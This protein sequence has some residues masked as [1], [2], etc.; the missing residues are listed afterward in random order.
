MNKRRSSFCG[1][2][3]GSCGA[4]EE[5]I[6]P[7]STGK[8]LK[9][10]QILNKLEDEK[11][12]TR[13][14]TMKEKS[15][16]GA[17]ERISCS[18]SRTSSFGR[19]L[20]LWT[21]E[22][23]KCGPN[24]GSS[25]GSK[26][27]E[28][29][30]STAERVKASTNP[31]SVE[32]AV[33]RKLDFQLNKAMASKLVFGKQNSRNRPSADSNNERI[34]APET[35]SIQ[36][37]SLLDQHE[38]NRNSMVSKG[39]NPNCPGQVVPEL[40][41]DGDLSGADRCRRKSPQHLK[42]KKA[43]TSEGPGRKVSRSLFLSAGS[44]SDGKM[45]AVNVRR[46]ALEKT[47]KPVNSVD[48]MASAVDCS[49]LKSEDDQQEDCQETGESRVFIKKQKAAS[50]LP[51]LP[52]KEGLNKRVSEF[53][54]FRKRWDDRLF[55]FGLGFGV[56]FMITSSKKEI[57]KLRE[58]QEQT[59][60]LVKDLKQEV[61]RGNFSNGSSQMLQS[62][63][64]LPSKYRYANREIEDTKNR[65]VFRSQNSSGRLESGIS[66]NECNSS[67]HSIITTESTPQQSGMAQLEAELEAELERM[68]LDLSTERSCER[69]IFSGSEMPDN[70]VYNDLNASQ[71]TGKKSSHDQEDI[72]RTNYSLCPIELERRLHEVLQKRQ[73]DHITELE[74]DLKITED[75]L[76][77]KE[78]ELSW[79]KEHV[80]Q[81][82]EENNEGTTAPGDESIASMSTGKGSK[83]NLFFSYSCN[84]DDLIK[85]Q[86]SLKRS[87]ASNCC[88][89]IASVSSRGTLD[90][91]DESS[92]SDSLLADFKH[93]NNLQTGRKHANSLVHTFGSNSPHNSR[94][95]ERKQNVLLDITKK[96]VYTDNLQ[97]DSTAR[98][99]CIDMPSASKSIAFQQTK[100][101][102]PNSVFNTPLGYK[103]M[104]NTPEYET[105]SVGRREPRS[106]VLNKI[107]H[108]EALSRRDTSSTQSC[109][110][111]NDHLLATCHHSLVSC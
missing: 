91:R 75:E 4:L 12:D 53:P 79:W 83:K 90:V 20:S 42:T 76:L 86:E 100:E 45:T 62:S 23:S 36:E 102:I 33:C 99:P 82:L 25:T 21:S 8:G 22:F 94:G 15:Q 108:W 28:K 52:S 97:N 88:E 11:N 60:R 48:Q 41:I 80:L 92:N 50:C 84:G 54:G 106:P 27:K 7:V 107:K 69:E 109:D 105:Y 77:D 49:S 13:D 18:P 89:D 40:P 3:R 47:C 87:E 43:K 24:D 66:G 81:L 104:Q 74:A 111:D 64:D 19:C 37:G 95:T 1:F 57:E 67:A 6:V 73:E 5:N 72:D 14:S 61:R 9:D 16:S 34:K 35:P 68:E 93:L 78:K 101:F 46:S 29:S 58:L 59:E 85:D 2:S 44:A 26:G 10:F 98:E 55:N 70:I 31:S 65:M 17:K 32:K 51:A 56:V 103:K 71:I 110:M 63:E 38:P 30:G 96:A 39:A